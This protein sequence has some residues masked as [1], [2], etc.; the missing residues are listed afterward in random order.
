VLICTLPLT[1]ATR[2]LLDARALA[3]LP[4]GAYV[5]NVSRGRILRE[6]DLMAAIDAGH[7][8]GA[9]LDVFE[10]EPLP[11]DSPLW[12]HPQILCTAHVAAE[13]RAEIAA[14]QFVD[15]LRRARSGLPL[16]NVI[17][18]GRGY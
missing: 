10:T 16:V 12:R 4:R 13:P 18:R 9:A 2:G 14:A 6:A 3:R 17:D 7:L 1:A 8:A 15:N 5:V 11:V